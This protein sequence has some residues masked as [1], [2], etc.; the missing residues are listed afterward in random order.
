MNVEKATMP[1]SQ[2]NLAIDVPLPVDLLDSARRKS[3]RSIFESRI[4]MG[5]TFVRAESTQDPRSGSESAHGKLNAPGPLIAQVL[6]STRWTLP[7]IL[8]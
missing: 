7:T 4:G 1:C 6:G 3:S 8:L 2:R 5:T